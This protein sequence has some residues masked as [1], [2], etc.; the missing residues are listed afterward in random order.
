MLDHLYFGLW[1]LLCVFVGAWLTHRRQYGAGPLPDLYDVKRV[2]TW[3]R[4]GKTDPNPT[5]EPPPAP[6]KTGTQFE[7]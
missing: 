7:L 2:A 1:S 5:D 3:I 4:T 6:E